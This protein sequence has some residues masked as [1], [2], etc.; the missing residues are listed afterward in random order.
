MKS[1]TLGQVA[2]LNW[3]IFTLQ[4]MH[5]HLDQSRLTVVCIVQVVQGG[6]EEMIGAIILNL[7]LLTAHNW[8]FT[9]HAI[10]VM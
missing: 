9:A 4:G 8:P 6:G 7:L 1:T 2:K 5:I 3:C 10:T